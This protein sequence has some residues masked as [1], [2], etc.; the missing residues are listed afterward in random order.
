MNVRILIASAAAALLLSEGAHAAPIDIPVQTWVKR[1]LPASGEGACPYG[2]KH[3]RLTVNPTNGRIYFCGGDYSTDD[4]YLDSGRNEIYSY[5][6]AT[7]SW[8]QEFPYCAPTGQVQPSH[9]DEVG[10]VF[11]TARNKFWMIPG[12]MGV[13]GGADGGLCPSGTTNMIRWETMTWDPV[14]KVW[15]LPNVPEANVPTLGDDGFAQYDPVTDTIIQFHYTGATKVGIFDIKSN[16]WTEVSTPFSADLSKEYSVFDPVDRVIYAIE[17]FQNKVYR[18]EIDTRTLTVFADAP[19]GTGRAQSHPV[20]DSV[21]RVILWFDHC[22]NNPPSAAQ[23][24]VFHPTTKV[25]ETL[26]TTLPE[27]GGPVFGNCTVFDPVQNVLLVMGDAVDMSRPYFYLYR[28]GT[29]SGSPPPPPDGIAP[30]A[31]SD[32]RPR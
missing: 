1:I 18:Y 26:P 31:V 2:C 32:L 8:T 3:M 21:N 24:H 4:P 29:G 5:D 19:A 14:T 12:Y 16:S 25:W 23:F 28:Y 9:P 30:S 17:G 7:D 22:C 11:D 13:P 27:D 6:V 20:W 15:T 10:W